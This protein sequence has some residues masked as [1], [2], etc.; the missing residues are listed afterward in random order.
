MPRPPSGSSSPSVYWPCAEAPVTP[1][2]ALTL[3]PRTQRIDSDPSLPHAPDTSANCVVGTPLALRHD[4]RRG[5]FTGSHFTPPSVV[6]NMPVG[7][8]SEPSPHTQPFFS[9]KNRTACRP[10][11]TFIPTSDHLF[12]ASWVTS[13][14]PT[15]VP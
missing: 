5:P 15:E 3:P 8:A 11:I 4:G 12:P 7:K 9:S 10:G 14:T 2:S 1:A 13:I 6:V